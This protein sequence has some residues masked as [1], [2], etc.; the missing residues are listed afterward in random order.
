MAATLQGELRT[1]HS[2]TLAGKPQA[3][4]PRPS[5]DDLLLALATRRIEGHLQPQRHVEGRLRGAEILARW[6]ND[7]GTLLEPAAFLPAFESAGLM[8][9]LTDYMI[10]QALAAQIRLTW[11]RD[12]TISINIPTGIASSV[13]WAQQ[14]AQ[15]AGWRAPRPAA[16]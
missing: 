14:L 3:A 11:I 15:Q 10:E 16:W 13:D 2:A 1:L 12:L 7:D 9:P 8:R 6:R 4:T 5:R